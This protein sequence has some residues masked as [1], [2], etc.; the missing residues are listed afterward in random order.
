MKSYSQASQDL[1][2]A[3][4]TE[5]KREGFFVDLGCHDSQFH[6]N[7]YALETELDWRG[8]LVDVVGGCESRDNIFIKCDASNPNEQLALHYAQLP[9]VCDFLS[10]DVDDALLPVFNTIPWDK[11][12]FRVITLEHDGYRKGNGDRDRTR[13]MLKAMGYHLTCS[14]VMVRYPVH[15]EPKPFEDWYCWPELVNPELIKKFQCDK[16][17]GKEIVKR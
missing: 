6:N 13:A 3:A 12:T 16:V 8:I 9:L 17:L 7:T 5:N 4:M 10:L 15:E 1:F 14:D 11:T 2:V